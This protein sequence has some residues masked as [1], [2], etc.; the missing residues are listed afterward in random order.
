MQYIKTNNGK[1]ERINYLGTHYEQRRNRDSIIDRAN[2]K[3]ELEEQ[4]IKRSQTI[5]NEVIQEVEEG[6][7][8]LI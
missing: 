5:P 7:G 8:V 1:E 3:P 6:K 4:P 2:M